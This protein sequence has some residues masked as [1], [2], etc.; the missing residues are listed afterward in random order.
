MLTAR[1]HN[2]ARALRWY[3]DLSRA[4]S[5]EGFYR[6]PQ[7]WDAPPLWAPPP[8]SYAD[9]WEVELAWRQCSQRDRWCLKC[10]YHDRLHPERACRLILERSGLVLRPGSWRDYLREARFEIN[11][12]LDR[13]GYGDVRVSQVP[14]L[15]GQPLPA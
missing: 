2:W 8:I 13:S 5:L 15:F 4:Q 11:N 1:L 14:A 9:A 6:S 7:R 12:Q 3:P 10:H